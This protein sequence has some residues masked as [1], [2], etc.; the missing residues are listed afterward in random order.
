MSKKPFEAAPEGKLLNSS[1]QKKLIAMSVLVALV[2]AIFLFAHLQD[3]NRDDRELDQIAEID[4]SVFQEQ[5]VVPPFDESLL[6]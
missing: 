2:A 1:E 3:A 5:L 6:S 4:D